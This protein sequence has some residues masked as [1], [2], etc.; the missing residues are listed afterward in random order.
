MSKKLIDEVKLYG[1]GFGTNAAAERAIDAVT[2][3]IKR[4]VSNGDRVTIRGFGTFKQT[5]RNQRVGRNPR[6]GEQVTI[7]ARDVLTFKESK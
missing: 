3:A 5:H 1:D 4:V 2:T 7:A 6:T